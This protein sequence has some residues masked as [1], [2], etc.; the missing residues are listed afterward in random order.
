[1]K[2]TNVPPTIN[3]DIFPPYPVPDDDEENRFGPGKDDDRE[4]NRCVH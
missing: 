4:D 3:S 2:L 1:M